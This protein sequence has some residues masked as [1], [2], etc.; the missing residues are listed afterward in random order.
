MV[1]AFRT[2]REGDPDSRLVARGFL[3]L[4]LCLLADLATGLG[5]LPEVP[6]V[7]LAG[8]TVLFLCSAR[9]LSNRFNRDYREL[10]ALRRELEARIAERPRAPGRQR[11]GLAETSRT[12]S[13]TGLLNRRGFLERGTR[14]IDRSRRSGKPLCVVMADADHFL[15]RHLNDLHGHAT[16]DL[17][18]QGLAE[19]LRGGAARPGCGGTL[20]GRGVHPSPARNRPP[21]CFAGRRVADPPAGT[22]RQPLRAG[23][24]ELPVTLSFG[25]AEHRPERGLE[26]TIAHADA[27]L[28]RAKAEGRD[29]VVA[30]RAV[31][32]AGAVEPGSA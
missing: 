4:V 24:L 27:A 13:L 2:G 23:D 30:H 14:E 26:A 11:Q 15:E 28:Y 7:P 3:V 9:S 29:R 18:L 1:R 31:P 5:W 32:V 22:S 6:A 12:D 21:R 25:L 16:G 19:L 8:F 20:G 17:A 10:P